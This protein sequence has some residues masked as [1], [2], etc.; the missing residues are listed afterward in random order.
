MRSTVNSHPSTA[1]LPG[2]SRRYLRLRRGSAVVELAICLPILMTIL[3]A[4]TEA[5]NMLHVQQTLKICAF[6]G[7]RVGTVPGANATNV[8][9][10]CQTLLDDHNVQSYT[11]ALDPPDPSTLNQGDYF[12]VV[13]SADFGPNSLIGGWLYDGRTLIRSVALR[14]E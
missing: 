1:I 9:Y 11:I 13:I 2:S 4:T 7:A 6:E 10:Q 3:L 12:A 14:A 5:C 8:V